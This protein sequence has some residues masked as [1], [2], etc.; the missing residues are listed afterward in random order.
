M[1]KLDV[2]FTYN[3][4]ESGV[5]SHNFGTMLNKIKHINIRVSNIILFHS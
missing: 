4:G 1:I 5:P 3:V 2:F